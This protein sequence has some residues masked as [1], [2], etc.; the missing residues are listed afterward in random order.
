MPGFWMLHTPFM[1]VQHQL[2]AD[3][4][5]KLSESLTNMGT[6]LPETSTLTVPDELCY[7][8]GTSR[9]VGTAC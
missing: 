3:D 7:S 8:Q 2:G 6:P 9:I 1:K 5:Q 4:I